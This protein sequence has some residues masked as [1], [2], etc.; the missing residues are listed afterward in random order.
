MAKSRE[1][2]A[3][4][5]LQ[6]AWRGFVSSVMRFLAALFEWLVTSGMLRVLSRMAS[7]A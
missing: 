5:G 4:D 3:D 1:Q 2:K 7:R 6:K